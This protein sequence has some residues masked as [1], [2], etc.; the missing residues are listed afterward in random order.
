MFWF[1]VFLLWPYSASLLL[2][3][4]GSFFIFLRNDNEMKTKLFDG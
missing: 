4:K 2:E 3:E 1:E